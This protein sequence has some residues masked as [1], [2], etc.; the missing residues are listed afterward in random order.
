MSVVYY[1]YFKPVHTPSNQQ[2]I[3]GGPNVDETG[4]LKRAV[5]SDRG[6]A[7]NDDIHVGNYKL[8]VDSR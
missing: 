4:A 6:G 3:S 5:E 8:F 2:Q 1:N 7:V